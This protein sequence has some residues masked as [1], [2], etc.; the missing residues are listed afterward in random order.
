MPICSAE[1][2]D[3]ISVHN[4]FTQ[5]YYG[6][7]HDK[8]ELSRTNFIEGESASI[9]EKRQFCFPNFGWEGTTQILSR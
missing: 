4:Q 1:L 5:T 6:N 9:P 3:M 2:R 8:R 7:I